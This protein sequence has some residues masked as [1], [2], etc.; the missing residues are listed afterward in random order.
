MSQYHVLYVILH[1]ILIHL[2]I[3]VAF[4]AVM[5]YVSQQAIS[6]VYKGN[7]T[8][9]R[10]EHIEWL[11]GR[12]IIGAIPVLGEIC[13]GITLWRLDRMVVAWAIIFY[14][15][16][17]VNHGV[18]TCEYRRKLWWKRKEDING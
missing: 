10:E 6:I 7:V 14:R 11:L 5:E 15:L 9:D 4:V 13:F 12:V 18:M 16:Y 17:S 3:M 2:S 8:W 1:C